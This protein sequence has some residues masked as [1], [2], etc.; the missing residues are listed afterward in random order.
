MRNASRSDWQ[1]RLPAQDGSLKRAVQLAQASYA[2]GS[3][4]PLNVLVHQLENTKR[5]VLKIISDLNSDDAYVEELVKVATKVVGNRDDVVAALN[6]LLDERD[7]VLT[8]EGR[9]RISA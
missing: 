4:M 1:S 2:E 5:E 6:D 3:E 9:L 7:A 8:P